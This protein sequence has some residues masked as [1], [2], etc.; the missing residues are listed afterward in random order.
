MMATILLLINIVF[1][2]NLSS[3]PT[4]IIGTQHY[5]SGVWRHVNFMVY[6]PIAIVED[7]NMVCTSIICMFT[8][9]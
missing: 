4:F 8:P 9:G 7:G 6:I 1:D 3:A 2:L 5:V